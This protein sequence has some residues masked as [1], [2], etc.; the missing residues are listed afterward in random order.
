MRKTWVGILLA[1][2]VPLTA[3]R[4]NP[5]PKGME[6]QA[7]LAAGRE[8]ALALVDGDYETVWERLR[9]DVAESTGPEQL[10]ELVLRQLDGAGVYKEIESTMATGQ[11]SDGES[12]GVAVLYC[13]FSKKDVVF[14]V[15][16]DPDMA[17][18]GLEIRPQ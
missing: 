10:Q 13:A 9:P 5:L 12:Y 14:R 8:V 6:E 2:L 18:I 4:G 11:A 1:L 7:L 3:C 16:F 17:L 15:A